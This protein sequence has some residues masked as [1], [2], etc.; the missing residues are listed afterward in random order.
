[1]ASGVS[2]VDN[3]IDILKLCISQV[4]KDRLYLGIY[5]YIR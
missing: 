5:K 3:E 2:S 1:M 4:F